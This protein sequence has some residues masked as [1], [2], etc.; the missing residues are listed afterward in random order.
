MVA[1]IGTE[2]ACHGDNRKSAPV[3]VKRYAAERETEDGVRGAK[4]WPVTARER[5]G[6]AWRTEDSSRDEEAAREPGRAEVRCDEA[7]RGENSGSDDA[8]SVR[9]T[10]DER[11]NDQ[12][13]ERRPGDAQP[14]RQRRA[15]RSAAS[16]LHAGLAGRVDAATARECVR[17]QGPA[18]EAPVVFAGALDDGTAPRRR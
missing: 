3:C 10:S 17:G 8:V 5:V 11:R 9:D 15:A 6:S 4:R 12:E 16:P 2:K 13:E 7:A 14:W 18:A 1:A